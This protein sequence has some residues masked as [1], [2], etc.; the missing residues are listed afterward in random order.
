MNPP[1]GAHVSAAGG[2][3]KLLTRADDLG[4]EAVQL[5]PSAPQSY[6]GPNFTPESAATW[7]QQLEERQWPVF[8]HGIY[9]INLASED[10]RLWHASIDS[11]VSY[12]NWAP[13]LQSVGSI[14]HAGSHK[15]RGIEAVTDRLRQA[16]QKIAASLEPGAGKFIIENTAGGGGTLGRDLSELKLL[17]DIFSSELPTAICLDTCHLFASGVDLRQAAERQK[18]FDDFDRQIGLEHLAA[19]HLNDSVFD[20]DSKRDRHANL[21]EGLIG[22]DALAAVVTDERLSHVPFLLEV[23][24]SGSGPDQENISRALSWRQ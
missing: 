15:G 6:R 24:G 20:L 8:F 7:R 11:V 21:G 9:L 16:A 13:R 22:A 3:E 17:Y 19:I 4:V 1:I 2:L 10:D 12:L 5:H 14:T 18:W 23:P